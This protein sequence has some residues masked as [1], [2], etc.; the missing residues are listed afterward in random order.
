MLLRKYIA[1]L[2]HSIVEWRLIKFA[3]LRSPNFD[4][5]TSAILTWICRWDRDM[6][7]TWPWSQHG[8]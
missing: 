1:A 3:E 7:V 4:F 8:L 5:R 2:L 6:D